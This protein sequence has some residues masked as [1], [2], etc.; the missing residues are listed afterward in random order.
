MNYVPQSYSIFCNYF[1]L[2]H[3]QHEAVQRNNIEITE[4]LLKAGSMVNA[5]GAENLTPLHEAVFSKNVNIAKLLVS[6][7]AN[8]DVRNAGGYSPR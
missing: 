5:T 1:Y 7:G 4:I 6:F 2:L 8:I 3:F